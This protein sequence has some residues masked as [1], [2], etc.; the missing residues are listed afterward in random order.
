LEYILE[1]LVKRLSFDLE[2]GYELEFEYVECWDCSRENKHCNFI[3]ILWINRKQI[4]G[5]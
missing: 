3:L 2:L 5:F 4:V 1:E